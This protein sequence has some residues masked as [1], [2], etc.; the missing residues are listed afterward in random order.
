MIDPNTDTAMYESADIVDYLYATYGEGATKSDYLLPSTFLTGWMPSLLRFGRGLIRDEQGPAEAP[1][2]LLVLYSYDGNQFARLVREVRSMWSLSLGRGGV[3]SHRCPQARV[4][5]QPAA[6]S[7]HR[8][9]TTNTPVLHIH[10]STAARVAH[11]GGD[12]LVPGACLQVLCELELPYVL[13]SVGKGSPQ[14][15]RLKAESGKTT[16]PYLSDPNTGAA[17]G[18]SEDIIAYLYKTYGQP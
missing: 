14:R 5:A 18:D 3:T 17:L 7:A 4:S 10:V 16:V 6:S 13:I 2:E 9:G 12:R 8:V 15:E 1:K 11:F